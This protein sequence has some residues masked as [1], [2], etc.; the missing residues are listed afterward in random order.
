VHAWRVI[1]DAERDTPDG[2]ALCSADEAAGEDDTGDGEI[3]VT[4]RDHCHSL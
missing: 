4:S 3:G 2:A 1:G